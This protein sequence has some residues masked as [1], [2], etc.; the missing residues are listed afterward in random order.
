MSGSSGQS[1][2]IT[3]CLGTFSTTVRK[4]GQSWRPIRTL[5]SRRIDGIE[6]VELFLGDG[7][8]G[9]EGVG[10]FVGEIGERG[11]EVIGDARAGLLH[12]VDVF[13]EAADVVGAADGVG[14]G[15]VEGE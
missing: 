9:T 14:A 13:A 2:W 3:Q 12:G 1:W 15:L 5:V 6:G 10:V 11:E 4:A 8:G 7:R